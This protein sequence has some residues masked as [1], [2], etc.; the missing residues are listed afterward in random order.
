MQFSVCDTFLEKHIAQIQIKF[1][2]RHG[3]ILVGFTTT[4]AIS[5]YHH[6]SF[7]FESRSLQGVLKT[8]LCDKVCRWLSTG[9]PISTTNK[10][11]SHDVTQ[12]LL[13]VALNTITLTPPNPQI[14]LCWITSNVRKY[15]FQIYFPLKIVFRK[16][17]D[18]GKNSSKMTILKGGCRWF[19]LYFIDF[20][21]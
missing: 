9:S 18:T 15:F 19:Q 3:H 7:E 10:I 17:Q 12:I 11:G 14:K 16:L 13:K 20:S 6:W 21:F 1:R 2:D 8:T 4:C 5:T